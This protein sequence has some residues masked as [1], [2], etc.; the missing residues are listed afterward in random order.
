MRV[1]FINTLLAIVWA[2]LLGEFSAVNLTSGFVVGYLVLWLPYHLGGSSS[3]FTKIQRWIAFL[4]FYG[5]EV[6]RSSVRVAR[7]VLAPQ[8]RLKPGVIAVPLDLQTD[9]EITV[10]AN[11]ITM[12][13]GSMSIDVSADHSTLYVHVMRV[14][15]PDTVRREIKDT[16]EDWVRVIFA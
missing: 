14:Q 15:D 2:G 10:L 5:W 8:H 1:F 3:Y 6:L 7:D 16:L 13:P 11:L 9:A 12:T 4:F